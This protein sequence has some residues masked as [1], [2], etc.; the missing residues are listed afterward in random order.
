MHSGNISNGSVIQISITDN[1][2]S[3]YFCWICSSRFRCA[4]TKEKLTVRIPLGLLLHILVLI[5]KREK[6]NSYKYFNR[7]ISNNFLDNYN[8]DFTCILSLISSLYKKGHSRKSFKAIGLTQPV[9]F[10]R[11]LAPHCR[12]SNSE[13]MLHPVRLDFNLAT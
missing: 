2:L 7:A 1:V 3:S 12:S 4:Y 8:P 9:S 6:F 5:P 11:C 13:A 10:D